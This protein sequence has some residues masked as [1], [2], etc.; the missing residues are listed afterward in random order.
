M[1]PHIKEWFKSAQ[2]F[3]IQV[4]R[5]TRYSGGARHAPRAPVAPSLVGERAGPLEMTA[6]AQGSNPAVSQCTHDTRDQRALTEVSSDQ[7]LEHPESVLTDEGT[8]A[9]HTLIVGQALAGA[10]AFR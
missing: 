3:A 5:L 7:A 8:P 10:T 9:M 2:A 1:T 6:A 4:G